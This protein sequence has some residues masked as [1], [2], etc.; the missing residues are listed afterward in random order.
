IAALGAGFGA[1]LTAIN[2][3]VP[4]HFPARADAALTLAHA[5]VGVG[6]ALPAA[7]LPVAIHLGG[8]WLLPLLIGVVLALLAL[9]AA[10]EAFPATGDGTPTSRALGRQ[11]WLLACAAGIYGVCEALFGNWGAIFLHDAVHVDTIT[12]GF[13]L[14]LFWGALTGGRLVI[15]ALS[16]WI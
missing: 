8:W 2:T 11:A 13:A 5:L 9:A 7:L 15:A 14:S 1:T 12:S 16:R 6:T 3:F 10:P 4:R